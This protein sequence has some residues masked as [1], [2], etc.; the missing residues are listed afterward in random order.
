MITPNPDNVLG[1]NVVKLEDLDDPLIVDC[2][3][4]ISDELITGV[5]VVDA[6]TH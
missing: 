4:E 2:V 3:A 6:V 5:T 1:R